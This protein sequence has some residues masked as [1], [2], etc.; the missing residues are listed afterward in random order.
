MHALR[1]AAGPVQVKSKE[2][3]KIVE[4]RRS[5]PAASSSDEKKS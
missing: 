5:R 3:V 1:I 4:P 2:S